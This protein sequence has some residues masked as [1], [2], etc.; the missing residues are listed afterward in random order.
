MLRTMRF[1]ST[2]MYSALAL[3]VL[4]STPALAAPARDCGGTSKLTFDPPVH[5][6]AGY[7]PGIEIDSRGTI[8]VTAPSAFDRNERARSSFLWRSTDGGRSFAEIGGE[9]ELAKRMVGIEGDVALDSRDRLYFLDLTHLD[10]NIRRYSDRGST[11]DYMRPATASVQVDDRPWLAAHGAD[12]VYV[13][14]SDHLTGEWVVHASSDAGE[15]FDPVG[16]RLL[17][18]GRVGFIDADPRSDQVYVI[19]DLKPPLTGSRFH[20]IAVWSSSD[21]AKTWTRSV[22]G[23]YSYADVHEYR[24][25]GFPTVAVSPV[26]GSVYALWSQGD[27]LTLARSAD[28]GRTWRSR[29]IQPIAGRYG[30][31]WLTT[32]PE[33]Q[34]GLVFLAD[35]HDTSGDAVS[36]YA[37]ILS[38]GCVT[39]RCAQPPQLGKIV[40]DAMAQETQKDFFQA[41]FAPDGALHVALTA[42]QDQAD[43]YDAR[44]LHVK[45]SRAAQRAPAACR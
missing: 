5:V 13:M 35:P 44:V 34:V 2:K 29:D 27:R 28:R 37:M 41:E 24:F 31:P 43:V 14:S 19:T 6:G 21:R 45:Q 4:A 12:D 9:S 32:G 1:R 30:Q 23:Q 3:A 15:T 16:S 18:S 39:G 40:E 8:Y 36:A 25:L 7:E 11:L 10:V 17:G 33:G 22:V 20:D 38:P 26:D 42:P